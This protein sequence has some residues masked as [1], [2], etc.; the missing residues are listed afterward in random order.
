MKSTGDC[1]FDELI[2]YNSI[3]VIYSKYPY[4]FYYTLVAIISCACC[5][6]PKNIKAQDSIAVNKL[7]DSLLNIA[8]DTQDKELKYE[9]LLEVSKFWSY[10]DTTKAY[11]ALKNAKKWMSNPPSDFQQGLYHL[12]YAYILTETN[13]KAAKE[14]LLLADSLLKK[15]DSKKHY[16][17]LAKTWN[18]YGVLIQQEDKN[19]EFMKNVINKSLPYA[20]LSGDSSEVAYQLHNIAVQMENIVDYQSASDY[21]K[22]A[23]ITIRNTSGTQERKMEIF[24]NAARNE[25][26]LRNFKQAREYL[27]SARNIVPEVSYSTTVPYYYRT[28]F[29]Y[30]RHQKDKVKALKNY[31]IALHSAKKLNDAYLM[32]DLNFEMY[33]F[34][35]DFGDF[36][37]AK[38][39][40]E[41]S[42][43]TRPYNML[44]NIGLYH[45][46]MAKTE[47]ELQN[48]KNAYGHMDSV[49]IVLDSLYITD[50]AT[51][52]Q[53][54]ELEHETTEKENEILRLQASNQSKELQ[55]SKN[56]TWQLILG[57]GF[58]LAISGALFT[59]R[60]S[61]KNKKLLYQSE[62]LH[63]E[64]LRSLK[65]REKLRQF[66][67][68]LQGQEAERNRL[69]KDLHDGLGG[70][71]AGVKLKLSAIESKTYKKN[72]SEES[73][74]VE[75]VIQQLDY[76]VDELRRIAH[77]MMPE[78]LR[79]GGLIP[80]LCDLCR[81]MSSPEQHVTFQD[82]GVNDHYP[83]QLRIAAYR[84]V[85]ELI[86]NAI[87]HAEANNI[88]VQ[89]SELDG[90]LFITIEDNGK[91]MDLKKHEQEKG[92]G[93]INIENRISLL[94]GIVETLSA[95]GE[96]TTV[97]IQIPL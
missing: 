93:L 75:D 44:R 85:Q 2:D 71:L 70:L 18:N 47:Y 45:Y 61:K 51:K 62:K 65:Q 92:L 41:L 66:D 78:S 31:E 55:L 15:G 91:G 53:K 27:D 72:H 36:Q 89:C 60:I 3:T 86:T 17:Y 6:M 28:E 97:N 82:L 73:N 95:P 22:K 96:G 30:Y 48:Y 7:A 13:A 26:F 37:K 25:I 49:A 57:S 29:L 12:H 11:Q 43:Q 40:L 24:S 63:Q 16:Y 32:T 88:I 64:E 23:I 52:I 5:I 94:N 58:I 80:A 19:E 67:A 59:W 50:V 4:L 33:A 21:Y 77:N 46:E 87:K 81:Y 56:R 14:Q 38:H 90:W 39:Y 69:A 84:V 34:Y 68:M 1:I 35:R 54:L 42:Q 9:K 10:H 76:S 20:R 74:D 83:E 79:Y 8:S